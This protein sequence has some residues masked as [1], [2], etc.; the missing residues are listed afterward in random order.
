MNHKACIVID[1]LGGTTAVARL[2]HA[3]V[4]TVHSWRVNG[5]PKSRM[6]H[7]RLAAGAEGLEWPVAD[8]DDADTANTNTSSS[9]KSNDLTAQELGA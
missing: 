6:A 9:G 1:G 7:L 3:P 4:S 5:I 2:V 8:H